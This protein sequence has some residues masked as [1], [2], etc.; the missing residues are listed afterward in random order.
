MADKFII[1]P[2]ERPL[3]SDIL[4]IRDNA[5]REIADVLRYALSTIHSQSS[6]GVARYIEK[7]IAGL[8]PTCVA[9]DAFITL[10]AGMLLQDSTTI[11]PAPGTYDSPYRVAFSRVPMTVSLPV[12]VSNTYYLLEAQMV[13]VTVATESRDVMNATTRRFDPLTVDKRK[14]W[15]I[16][17]QWVAGDGT[18]YPAPSSGSGFEGPWVTVCG[19]LVQAGGTVASSA[20]LVDLRPTLHSREYMRQTWRH[21]AR[22]PVLKTAAVPGAAVSNNVY[23]MV[24]EALSNQETLVMGGGIKLHFGDRDSTLSAI[25]FSATYVRDTL[26]TLSANTWYYIYLCPWFD[27]GPKN[28]YSGFQHAGILVISSTAPADNIGGYNGGTLGLPAPFAN[29]TCPAGTAPLVGCLRRNAANTGWVPMRAADRKY[30]IMGQ[31]DM[32]ITS[33]GSNS[34]TVLMLDSF[35]AHAVSGEMRCDLTLSGV[36]ASTP[37]DWAVYSGNSSASSD[38]WERAKMTIMTDSSGDGSASAK[39]KVAPGLHNI[40]AT[41]LDGVSATASMTITP[42]SFEG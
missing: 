28:Y 10:S 12:P 20:D 17:T 24:D 15:R 30:M 5:D 32:D 11:A 23:L 38:F 3:S 1:N 8:D 40:H 41:R 34:C 14:E 31:P 4:A 36:T 2:R 35:P 6:G 25:D 33:G 13:E 37:T 39:L 16:A 22:V 18:N 26:T 9:G 21:M 19:V 7:V 27:V 42:V 29:A